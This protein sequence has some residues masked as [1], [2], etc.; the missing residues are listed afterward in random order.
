M[1]RKELAL[2]VLGVAAFWGMVVW[3]LNG[4][5]AAIGIM[6]VIAALVTLFAFGLARASASRG[7]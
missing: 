2:I 7:N 5:A 3:L 4:N 6:M 1:K